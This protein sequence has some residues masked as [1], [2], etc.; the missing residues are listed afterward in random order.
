MLKHYKYSSIF[1]K[2]LVC[3]NIHYRDS[4]IISVDWYFYE[5]ISN[6]FLSLASE[7]EYPGPTDTKLL[8]WMLHHSPT[9]SWLWIQIFI[10]WMATFILSFSGC[11]QLLSSLCTSLLSCPIY[12]PGKTNLPNTSLPFTGS[13]HI[14]C[15][16]IIS[17]VHRLHTQLPCVMYSK[18]LCT[19]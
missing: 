15:L 13:T 16:V 4:Q 14:S 7:F 11:P 9:N 6:I 8:D 17:Y 5:I 12:S 3:I 19:V 18:L 1:V 2:F 10:S